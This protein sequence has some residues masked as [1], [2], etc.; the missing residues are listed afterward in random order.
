MSEASL[1]ERMGG[2]SVL[3]PLCNDL[4]GLHASDPLTAPWFS[5]SS[6]WNDRTADEV[7]EHVFNFFSAGIGG[8][9]EYKGRSMA[10]AHKKMREMKPITE[11]AFHALCYHVLTT[12]KKHNAG[13]DKE[14]EE[15]LGIL[16]SLKPQVMQGVE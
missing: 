11:A 7:K 13:G 5:P 2:E 15:V 4:Y 12:M 6:E 16:Q 8:P 1:Y 9:H 3:R 14:I 10:D